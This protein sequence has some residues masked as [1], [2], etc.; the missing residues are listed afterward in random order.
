MNINFFE[1]VLVMKVYI[2]CLSAQKT[3][4]IK[5][6]VAGIGYSIE[7]VAIHHSP[8]MF[9]VH[10]DSGAETHAQEVCHNRFP[11]SEGWHDHCINIKWIPLEDILSGIAE[12]TA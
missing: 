10:D 4:E 2:G 8:V 12:I 3:T 1:E 9:A 11:L 6:E 7:N 5:K